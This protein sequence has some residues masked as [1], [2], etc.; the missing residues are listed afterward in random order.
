MIFDN[1][2]NAKNYPEERIQ[3]A[4]TIMQDIL[5]DGF[6]SE[7]IVIDGDDFYIA[8]V[9]AMTKD[10]EECLLESHLKYIDVHYGVENCEVIYTTDVSDLEIAIEYDPDRDIRFHKG[11]GLTKCKLLPNHFMV[12]YPQDAHMVCVKDGEIG[13]FK[14]LVAKI[15]Y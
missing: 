7:N 13:E 9:T 6:P 12:C 15:K 3:K 5:K 2:K 14:K 8:P 11:E 4:L 10:Y 1:I